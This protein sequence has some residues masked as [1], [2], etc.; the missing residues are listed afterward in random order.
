MSVAPPFDPLAGISG[1]LSDLADEKLLEVLHHLA[2]IPTSPIVPPLL[3][4]VRP[5]LRKLRLQ[6]PVTLLRL[7]CQPFEDLLCDAPSAVPDRVPRKE[8]ARCWHLLIER[9]PA[10]YRSFKT[11]IQGLSP[12]APARVLAFSERLWHW[13]ASVYRQLKAEQEAPPHLALIRDTLE[14]AT[15]IEAFKRAVPGRPIATLG[16]FEAAHLDAGLRRLAAEGLPADA[17]LVAVAARLAN[18]ADLLAMHGLNGANLSAAALT[19]ITDFAIIEIEAR[20]DQLTDD[21]AA[22]GPDDVTRA[23]DQFMLGFS[24]ARD[25]LGAGRRA[26]LDGRMA[27]A[28]ASV[29]RALSERVVQQAPAFIAAGLPSSRTAPPT[30]AIIEAEDYARA[31]GRSRRA[32]AIIG[33]ENEVT[34][35]IAEARRRCEATIAESIQQTEVAPATRL[36]AESTI[37]RSIRFIELVDGPQRARELLLDARRRLKRSPLPSPSPEG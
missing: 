33:L 5:R 25:A 32:A 4:E 17:F 13:A 1:K 30:A 18:P 19:R 24:M 6:R 36:D 26:Q 9:D 2:E 37:Y 7:L 35:A 27:P 10:G 11:E 20:R 23:A 14:A 31:L 16:A 8:I 34:A 15:A 21:L 29:R 22:T 12:R 3:E 28:I